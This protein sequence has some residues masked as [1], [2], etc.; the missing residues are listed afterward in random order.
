MTFDILKV[1]VGST[2]HLNYLPIH[3]THQSVLKC[4]P[5]SKAKPIN[6]ATNQTTKT[7]RTISI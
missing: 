4:N 1:N 5:F 2:G 3:N 7:K 6:K